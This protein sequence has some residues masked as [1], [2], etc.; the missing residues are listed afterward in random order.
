M[1]M[2]ALS[3]KSLEWESLFQFLYDT[4]NSCSTSTK[5]LMFFKAEELSL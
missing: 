3:T 2:L 4:V 1:D 5:S